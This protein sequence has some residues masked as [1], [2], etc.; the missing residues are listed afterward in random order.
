[1][2]C[3]SCEKSAGEDV[4]CGSCGAIA[5]ANAQADHFSVLGV[6]RRFDIDAAAVEA[7]YKELARVL[8]PDRYA[9][10]DARARRASLQRSV[11]LN[12]AW[13]TLRDPVA[14]AEYL[15]SLSGIDV[16]VGAKVTVPPALLME[17]ME[18]REAL[19]DARAAADSARVAALAAD[20]AARQD[21]AMAVVEKGFARGDSARDVVVQALIEVRYYR[22][23]AEEV[24]VYE[25]SLADALV[26]HGG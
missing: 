19:G 11:Q 2:I 1:M 7:R 23:F 22:R 12:E 9:R 18:L 6:P 21:R 13:R 10:A 14:R 5:P 8:H 16:A 15:L 26:S 3:W 4:L 25:Q 24:A 17:I 20:V